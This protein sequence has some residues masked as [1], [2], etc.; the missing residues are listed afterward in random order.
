MTERAWRND[1]AHPCK[2]RGQRTGH[3]EAHQITVGGCLACTTLKKEEEGIS[4]EDRIGA[5]S[6]GEGL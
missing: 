4:Q 6:E 1:F 5:I 2:L 3:N